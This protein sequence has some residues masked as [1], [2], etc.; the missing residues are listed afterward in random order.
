MPL[1]S[2]AEEEEKNRGTRSSGEWN[3]LRIVQ[4]VSHSG[5]QHARRLHNLFSWS[6]VTEIRALVLVSVAASCFANTIFAEK[7]R[8]RTPFHRS[9][10]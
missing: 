4:A 8:V 9:P 2:A 10:S 3:F 5:S 1:G 6:A 7:G